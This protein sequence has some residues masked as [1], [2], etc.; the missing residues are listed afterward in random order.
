MY[1]MFEFS[2]Q[3]DEIQE[4]FTILNQNLESSAKIRIFQKTFLFTNAVF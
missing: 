4:F 2:C 1:E 3:N